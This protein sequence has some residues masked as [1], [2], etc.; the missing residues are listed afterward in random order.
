MVTLLN[1]SRLEYLR[2][3]KKTTVNH[4]MHPNTG[5]IA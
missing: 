2:L 3:L 5:D 1:E 4:H